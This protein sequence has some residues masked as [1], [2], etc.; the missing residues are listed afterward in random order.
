M[1]IQ[2]NLYFLS[3]KKVFQLNC[4]LLMQISWWYFTIESVPEYV[5]T[6]R[7][8]KATFSICSHTR[9]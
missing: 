1:N 2:L 3:Y 5:S 6:M 7:A 9:W 4:E 8:M